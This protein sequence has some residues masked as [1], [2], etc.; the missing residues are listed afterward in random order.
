MLQATDKTFNAAIQSNF[1][2]RLNVVQGED[3]LQRYKALQTE[4]RAQLA[5]D[6]AE[7]KAERAKNSENKLIDQTYADKSA[8]MNNRFQQKPSS[9]LSGRSNQ[10]VG[11]VG[12]ASFNP[13][14]PLNISSQSNLGILNTPKTTIPLS[15]MTSQQRAE[16]FNQM[17]R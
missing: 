12:R 8:V 17:F 16:Y 11:L 2:N 15:A 14:T 5:A 13:N 4:R 3:I 7:R 1:N 10:G 6:M 9:I